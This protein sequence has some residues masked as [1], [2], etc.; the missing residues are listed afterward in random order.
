MNYLKRG[1]DIII[2]LVLLI[3]L[4]PLFLLI[5]LLLRFTMGRPVLF[6]QMRPGL[7]GKPFV[8]LK[9]RTMTDARDEEGRFLL[10]E[11]RLTRLGRFLRRTSLDELPELVNVKYIS[12]RQ[13]VL[14]DQ[15][16]NN[17]L[18]SSS[19]AKE[20]INF[21]R[22]LL[23]WSRPRVNRKAHKIDSKEIAE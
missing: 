1:F 22:L 7:H 17:C 16:K 12:I 3:L 10:D 19:R 18:S 9:F 11:K 2:S 14:M 8:M 5:A 21:Y 15:Y 4:L 23:K 6:R 20:I 13:C